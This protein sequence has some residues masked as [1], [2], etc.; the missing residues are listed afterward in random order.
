MDRD[1]G[2]DKSLWTWNPPSLLLLD[3]LCLSSTF[4]IPRTAFHFTLLDFR[5]GKDLK[6]HPW[7]PSYLI[8]KKLKMLVQIYPAVCW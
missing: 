8:G 2:M 6:N 5:D 4:N 1:M 7:M 3:I